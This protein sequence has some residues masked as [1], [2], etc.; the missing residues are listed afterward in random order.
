MHLGKQKKASKPLEVLP[1]ADSALE[2]KR[3]IEIEGP[4]GIT[5]G[6]EIVLL[7]G[8]KA[9]SKNLILPL[10]LHVIYMI[11]DGPSGKNLVTLL[12]DYES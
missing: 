1:L 4:T 10:A 8:K 6:G 9:I 2:G 3:Y 12:S 7:E 5:F 11:M